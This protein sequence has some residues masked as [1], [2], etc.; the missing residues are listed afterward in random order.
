MSYLFLITSTINSDTGIINNSDRY[1]QTL[2]TIKSIKNKVID[3]KIIVVDSSTTEL[4]QKQLNDISK[5]VDA[6]LVA[7]EIPSIK[8]LSKHG[9]KSHAE[10]ELMFIGFDFIKK[11]KLDN[12]K[13]VFKISGRYNLNDNFDIS[14]YDNL[15]SSFVFKQGR[16]SWKN[17]NSY[18]L[19]TRLWSF[20]IDL[21]DE[22]VETYKHVYESI[23]KENLDIEH[24]IAK[25]IN[26]DKLIEKNIVGLT[27]IVAS[28]GRTQHD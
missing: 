18:I 3:P 5:E 2:D 14:F 13:R 10:T 12:L 25:H 21:L 23:Q 16:L 11:M 26:K 6:F 4:S 27:G 9:L 28:D 20:S 1:F 8:N 7:G 22:L 15:E 17:D 19:D 24:S